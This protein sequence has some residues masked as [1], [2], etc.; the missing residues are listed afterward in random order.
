MQRAHLLGIVQAV[1][2]PA[3]LAVSAAIAALFVGGCTSNQAAPRPS[4]TSADITA[5][6]DFGNQVIIHGSTTTPAERVQLMDEVEM[7][8]D[9]NLRREASAMKAAILAQNA[10][11]ELSAA[12]SIARTCYALGL[13]SRTG[14]P[15]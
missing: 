13:V 1:K 8:Q 11:A 3:K 4:V 10:N 5:C 2:I 9:A 7:A 15:T 6:H 12:Q 14:Q